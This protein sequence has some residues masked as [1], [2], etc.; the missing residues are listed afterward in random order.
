M[1]YL[2]EIILLKLPTFRQLRIVHY[3]IFLDI[4]IEKGYNIMGIY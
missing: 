4:L 1:I 2:K 3:K